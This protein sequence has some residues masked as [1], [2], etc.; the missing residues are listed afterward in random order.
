MDL[1]EEQIDR[2][3]STLANIVAERDGLSIECKITKKDSSKKTKP[4]IETSNL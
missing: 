1:T 4:C 3:L 2:F